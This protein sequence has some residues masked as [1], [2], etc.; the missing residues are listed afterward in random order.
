MSR[1]GGGVT[2]MW[3]ELRSRRRHPRV[4]GQR[5]HDAVK[6]IWVAGVPQA[7]SSPDG[8]VCG[9]RP[10]PPEVTLAGKL[11]S[12]LGFAVPTCH[13]RQWKASRPGR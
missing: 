13:P 8:L 7:E 3:R 1:Q 2:G 4:E 12:P 10:Q 6:L 5:P 11:A 9:Q